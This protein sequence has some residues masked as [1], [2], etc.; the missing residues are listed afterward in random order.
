MG[1]FIGI[2]LVGVTIIFVLL[3]YLG[4]AGRLHRIASTEQIKK[5]TLSSTESSTPNC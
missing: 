3:V 2:V 1:Y 4:R 5:A